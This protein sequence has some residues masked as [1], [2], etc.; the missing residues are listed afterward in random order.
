[1][2]YKSNDGLPRLAPL[3]DL[4]DF[5]VADRNLDVRGWEVIGSDGKRL[6]KVDDLIVDRELM[7]VRYLDVDVDKNH[8]LPDTDA[9]HILVPIG[10]A[11]LDDDG[12]QVFVTM[13]QA[14]LSRFP[15]YR[16]GAVDADYEYR[17]M[18]AVTSPGQAYT[19]QSA[20]A[21][22]SPN[23]DF[24]SREQFDE[25]RFYSNR[26]QRQ[27][28]QDNYQSPIMGNS[29]IQEDIATIER[30]RQMLEQGTITHDEFTA[31]KRKA[32]GL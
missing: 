27:Q 20:A 14:S 19:Q 26:Q 18:H 13:D 2:T 4:K 32:I 6:G 9:R 12:D 1:M 16:G 29:P 30:L 15:F 31:L 21:T 28:T 10:A 22:T 23:A 24:Y 17:V 7:K 3:H 8:I 5:K 11:Q 25:N